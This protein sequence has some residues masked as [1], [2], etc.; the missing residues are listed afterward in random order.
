MANNNIYVVTPPRSCQVHCGRGGRASGS[1]LLQPAAT[2]H[3]WN[4]ENESPHIW[5]FLGKGIFGADPRNCFID[6]IL[7]IPTILVYSSDKSV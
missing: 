5:T 2:A 3:L 7:D 1:N 4:G 6:F